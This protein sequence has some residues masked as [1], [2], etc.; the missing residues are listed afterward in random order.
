MDLGLSCER[1]ITGKLTYLAPGKL[2]VGDDRVFWVGLSTKITGGDICGDPE[3]QE[4]ESCTSD[5]LDAAAKDGNLT[6]EV[7]IKEGIAE[8][9]TQV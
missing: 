9:V 7:A 3:T 6:V 5:E 2:M 4:A 1:R 8:S